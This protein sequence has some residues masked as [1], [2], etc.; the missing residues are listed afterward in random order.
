MNTFLEALFWEQCKPYME[1]NDPREAFALGIR[2]TL[3]F[4]GSIYGPEM[5]ASFK[6]CDEAW[7][8]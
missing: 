5:T 2:F 3:D 1:R 7:P 8:P 6:D 4:I